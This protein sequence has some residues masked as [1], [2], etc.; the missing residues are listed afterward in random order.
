MRRALLLGISTSLVSSLSSPHLEQTH[1][2]V[3][4][5][6]LASEGEAL[7]RTEKLV[8]LTSDRHR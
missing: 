3:F 5:T 1:L 8:W 6:R 4:K 7:Y 2:K